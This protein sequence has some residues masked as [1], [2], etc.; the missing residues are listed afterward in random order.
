MTNDYANIVS[1]IAA[2]MVASMRFRMNQCGDYRP[3]FV[4]VS[5]MDGGWTIGHDG[6]HIG[7]W[8]APEPVTCADEYQQVSRKLYRILATA[9]LFAG[10]TEGAV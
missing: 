3:L 2:D 1:R 10:E 9:P 4:Y 5:E 6:Q 8:K 7:Y